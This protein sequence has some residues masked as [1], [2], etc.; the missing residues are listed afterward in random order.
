MYRVDPTSLGHFGSSAIHY[1]TNQTYLICPLVD[2]EDDANHQLRKLWEIY[3]FGVR[4]EAT[5]SYTRSEQRA[6]DIMNE[7]CRRVESGYELGLLWKADRAP[8]PNN[9][10]SVLSRLE[11]VERRLQKDPKLLQSRQCIRGE[12]FCTKVVA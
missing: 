12:R 4:V 11:S 3:N 8:L 9:F 2:G 7:T 6:V 5:T 1:Q 10:K